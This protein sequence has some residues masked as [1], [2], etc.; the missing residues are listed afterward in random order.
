MTFP[1]EQGEVKCYIK[2]TMV[3]VHESSLEGFEPSAFLFQLRDYITLNTKEEFTKN[4]LCLLIRSC[5]IPEQPSNSTELYLLAAFKTN[6]L[7]KPS[8]PNHKQIIL[9]SLF[10]D[11]KTY[12]ATS[13]A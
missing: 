12:R 1:L 2:D 4:K 9:M 3:K 11:S 10:S 8:S 13:V 6:I 7:Y 5:R